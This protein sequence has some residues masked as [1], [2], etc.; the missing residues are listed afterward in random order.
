MKRLKEKNPSWSN[1]GIKS[2]LWIE[3]CAQCYI[4]IITIK[5]VH[6]ALALSRGQPLKNYGIQACLMYIRFTQKNSNTCTMTYPQ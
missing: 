4:W 2:R 6:N 3:K 5:S 1:D